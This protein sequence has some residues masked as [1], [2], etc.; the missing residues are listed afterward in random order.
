M[1]K[2]ENVE[3]YN[4]PNAI[5]GMRNPKK[6]WD[7]SDS[8]FIMKDND[9]A[10]RKQMMNNVYFDLGFYSRQG[11]FVL[12]ALDEELALKL[13]KAG[14]ADS[15]FMRQ[16]FVSMDITSSLSFY[17]D[18]DTYK[19]GTTSNSTSRMHTLTNREL[20]EEDFSWDEVTDVKIGILYQ[21][22]RLIRLIQI[23]KE[24]GEEKEAV[25]AWRNLIEILPSSFNQTRTWTAN[26]EVLRNVYHTRKN[27]KQHEFRQMCAEFNFY[28]CSKLITQK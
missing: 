10:S 8:Y 1:I 28:Q 22:N 23:L 12:G 16:I 13:I 9:G 3:I 5:K 11:D 17:H 7:K 26:Y 4:I 18:L 14:T 21:V 25:V 6:S 15:K 24:K 19:I 27:H 2:M 20:T